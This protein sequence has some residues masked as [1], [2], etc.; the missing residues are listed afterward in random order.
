MTGRTGTGRRPARKEETMKTYYCSKCKRIIDTEKCLACG[1]WQTRIPQE[2]DLCLLTERD[3][4][5]ST[6]LAD[7][8][9]QKGIPF[10]TQSRAIKGCGLTMGPR[11]FYVSYDRLAE[12]QAAEDGLFTE[13]GEPVQAAE[14]PAADAPEDPDLYGL[15]NKSYE[16][17]KAIR[18]RLTN[19]LREIREREDAIRDTIDEIDYLMELAEE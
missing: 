18:K 11:A 9:N 6:M 3:Y 15:E 19:T 14:E 8:L 10:M 12:A 4:V 7:I 17:L 16:E 1:S 2:D 13:D 5:Q